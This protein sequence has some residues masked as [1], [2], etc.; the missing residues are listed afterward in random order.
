M[1][2]PLALLLLTG[3]AAGTAVSNGNETE[4]AQQVAEMSG[5]M[6]PASTGG[7]LMA[8]QTEAQARV[9]LAQVHSPL[10]IYCIIVRRF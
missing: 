4:M 3:C 7:D 1:F 10:I 9:Q 5:E 6:I 2:L 8:A